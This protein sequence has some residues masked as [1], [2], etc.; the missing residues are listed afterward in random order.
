MSGTLVRRY[1]IISR[2]KL[3]VLR[4]LEFTAAEDPDVCSIA[5]QPGIVQTDTVIG[6]CPRNVNIGYNGLIVSITGMLRRFALDTLGLVGGTSVWLAT[7][8]A[9]SLSGRFVSANWC[10]DELAARKDESVAGNDLKMV[11]ER[12]FGLGQFDAPKA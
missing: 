10:M 9:R 2:T 8:S 1:G 6:N 3:A 11:Y 5:L 7:N 12:K 4:L